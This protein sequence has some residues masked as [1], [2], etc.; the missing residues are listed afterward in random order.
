MNLARNLVRSAALAL[1]LAAGGGLVPAHAQKLDANGIGRTEV[2]RHSY[3]HKHE[4]IQV[5]VDFGPGVK[6]P[7]HSHPGV[8][9]AY[10][11]SGEFE[12]ELD[13]KVVRLKAG[14]SLYIPAGA[15]HS[16]K[17][18]GTEVASELATYIVE[19]GKPVLT[20]DK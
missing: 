1:M 12:Y 8:E 7:K 15:V 6:F 16:A 3:D 9:L 20:L 14:E 2:V 18:V 11:L 10:V 13:G 5:K 4:A 19:K 17:N